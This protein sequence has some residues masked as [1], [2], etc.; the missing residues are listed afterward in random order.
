LGWILLV[1]RAATTPPRPS[2]RAKERRCGSIHNTRSTVSDPTPV[3]L[4]VPEVTVLGGSN[5]SN[6]A[7]ADLVTVEK[8][9][10]DKEVMD[11]VVA[12]KVIDDVMAATVKA[13]VVKEAGDAAMTKKGADN[14]ALMKWVL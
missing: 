6:L 12:K 1:A 11:A 5:G 10:V 8:A 7:V 9:T 13:A 3:E 4:R 2:V 14:V